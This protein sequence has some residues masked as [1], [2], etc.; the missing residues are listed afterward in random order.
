MKFR[1]HKKE[2]IV[3]IAC[4]VMLLIASLSN[5]KPK[6]FHSDYPRWSD[7]WCIDTTLYNHPDWSIIQA[8]DYLFMSDSA[9]NVKYNL[10]Y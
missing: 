2:M 8:E 1:L 6:E 7:G 4:I 10:K 3:V 9:F 5:N